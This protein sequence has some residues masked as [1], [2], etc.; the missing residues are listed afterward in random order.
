MV[1]AK[2]QAAKETS[3]RIARSCRNRVR[4]GA[5]CVSTAVAQVPA[6]I[7]SGPVE[8]RLNVGSLD[9]HVGGISATT[10]REQAQANA[11]KHASPGSAAAIHRMEI[12]SESVPVVFFVITA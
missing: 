9:G 12:Y 10:E 5:A 2:L 11:R 6:D 4:Q 3:E 7:K 1:I 8:D